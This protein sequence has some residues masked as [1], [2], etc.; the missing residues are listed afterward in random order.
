MT[1]LELVNTIT[2][3]SDY[4]PQSML[5]K[6]SDDYACVYKYLLKSG[7]IATRKEIFIALDESESAL[8]LLD[9]TVIEYIEVY[10]AF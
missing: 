4:M 9:K 2:Q 3:C 7:S 1:V 5:L 6:S 8:E 10:P